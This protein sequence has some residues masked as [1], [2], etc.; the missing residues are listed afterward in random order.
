MNNSIFCPASDWSVAGEY[1]VVVV[2]AGPGGIGAAVAAARGGSRVCLVEKTSAPGGMA[3]LGGCPHLMGFGM[4]GRQIVGGIGDELVRRLD[5]M[6]E[7]HLQNT[8]HAPD[9]EPIADR[10]LA[11][12]IIASIHGVQLAS[13]RLL[14][15]TGVACRFHTTVI[16]AVVEGERVAAVAIDGPDGASLLRA[17]SF[18]DASGDAGLVHRAGGRTRQAAPDES[19]TKTLLFDVANVRDFD[20]AA[21]RERFRELAEAGEV[22]IAIQDRFMGYAGIEPG[23]VH[24]NYTAVAGD[25]LQAEE[26]ARMDRELREQIQKGISWFRANFPGF[27]NC[28]L[29]RAAMTVGIRAGRSA[30]GRATITQED[31]DENTPVNEPVAI[32]LRRY[33]D[34]GT[35]SFAAAWRKPVEGIRSIPWRTL[36]S[37]DFTNVGLAGR[38]ISAEPRMG[39]CIRYIAQC[40][41]TGQAAGTA[42]SL[43]PSGD[44]PAVAYPVLHD[45]LR[46]DGAMLTPEK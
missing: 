36:L 14:E 7:A 33:G 22:P 9:P 44:L 46:A 1:D 18:I 8:E 28:F 23:V 41:A 25:A 34:H 35:K 10:P 21:V 43:A 24:L 17:R 15:E 13:W 4:G 19:M 26:L 31:I 45:R 27:E 37:A 20:H 29:A 5:A 12:D 3:T 11:S 32:G 6:G 42:A 39:T 38:T 40:L 16:G 30:L 2:G